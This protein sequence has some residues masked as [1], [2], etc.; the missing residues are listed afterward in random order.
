MEGGGARRRAGGGRG[1]M[2]VARWCLAR[3]PGGGRG[4]IGVAGDRRRSKLP[5]KAATD[6]GT[7]SDGR[8]KRARQDPPR[9]VR[10]E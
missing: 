8:R 7:E 6:T 5:R 3:L 2:Y 10:A 4:A 9:A 1:R